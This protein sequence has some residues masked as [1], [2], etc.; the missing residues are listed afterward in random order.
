VLEE[1]GIFVSFMQTVIQDLINNE[2]TIM[3][4]FDEA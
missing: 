2:S 3:K 1:T 4:D